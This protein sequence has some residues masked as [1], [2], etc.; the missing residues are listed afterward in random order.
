ML[1]EESEV[2]STDHFEQAEQSPLAHTWNSAVS[3]AVREIVSLEVRPVAA[4]VEKPPEKKI[5]CQKTKTLVAK[6]DPFF[7]PS[8]V[9]TK[10]CTGTQGLRESTFAR[11]FMIISSSI[12]F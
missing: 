7:T 4:I 8:N 5:Y 1:I 12:G 10:L 9:R 6:T 11:M 2:E 3:E